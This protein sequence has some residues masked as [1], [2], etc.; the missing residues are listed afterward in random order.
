MHGSKSINSVNART[1]QD[2]LS[3]LDVAQASL[4]KSVFDG[5]FD[6]ADRI[7]AE[8]FSCLSALGETGTIP[9]V[10]ELAWFR[11]IKRRH[12]DAQDELAKI[13]RETQGRHRK[14]Q[15]ALF[16]YSRV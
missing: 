2:L 3:D 6:A 7:N 5:E 15:A 11:E 8:I 12:C 9:N 13:L 10:T 16:A 14:V 1:L 4:D